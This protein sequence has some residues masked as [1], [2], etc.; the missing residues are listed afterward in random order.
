MFFSSKALFTLGAA[1]ALVAAV[2]V[3]GQAQTKKLTYATYVPDIYAMVRADRWFMDEV[4]KRTNG[5]ITFEPYYSGS[6]LK[7]S[8]ILPGV[9]AGA[10]DLGNSVPSAYNRKDYRLSNITLP[11][12][13]SHVDS[14]ALAFKDLYEANAKLRAEY[15]SKGLKLLYAP[16]YAEN[17]I[18][19]MKPIKAPSDVQGLKIR[20]VLAIGD[21]LAKLGASTLAIPW[22]D[23]LEGMQR[24]VVDAMS[25]APFDTAVA[26]GLHEIA[27]Y[28]SDMGRMG[29]YAVSATVISLRTW[30]SLDPETQKIMEQVAAETPAHYLKLINEE[31]DNAVRKVADRVKSGK[32]EV[33]RFSEADVTSMREKVGEAVWQEW[34]KTADAQGVSGKEMLEQYRALT[35]KYDTSSGYQPGFVRLG[36]ALGQ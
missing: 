23:A 12:I 9:A 14:V 2:P 25:A 6:L 21:A 29:S 16:A 34:I 13:T 24:G 31:V 8:D 18:W 33:F 22:P 3:A 1:I 15:E 19:S 10:A 20:A 27:K 35:A 5:K 28:G 32:L 30:K 4:Q 7:A 26:G 36:K 17:T 11:F